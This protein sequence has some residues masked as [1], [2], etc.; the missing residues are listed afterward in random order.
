MQKRSQ[1]FLI[2]YR[3]V[4]ATRKDDKFELIGVILLKVCEISIV[5]V[6]SGN[7]LIEKPESTILRNRSESVPFL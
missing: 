6:G 2:R 4:C 3:L 1:C 5:E 7:V